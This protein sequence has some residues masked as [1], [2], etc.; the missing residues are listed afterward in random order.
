MATQEELYTALRNAD[1]A[2]DNES[3][4]KLAAYI[5]QTMSQ[6]TA[7]SHSSLKQTN[8]GEYDP[9]SPEYQ[10]KYGATSG[11]ST[12][13]KFNAGAGKAFADLGR[14]VEQVGAGIADFV[15]PRQQTVGGL[16]SGRPVQ[17][18]VDEQRQNVA[19]SRALDA[20]LMNTTAGKVGNIAGNIAA[21]APALAIP[22]VNTLAGGAALGAA[23]GALQPSTS[24][25]ETLI[26]TGIGA[27]AAPALQVAGN[28][29]GKAVRSILSRTGKITQEPINPLANQS[30]G[31]AGAAPDMS[32]SSPALQQAVRKAAQDSGGAV[33]PEVL[34]RHLEADSLPVKMQLTR[35]QATQDPSLISVEQ[36]TR[37]K[38]P[39]LAKH[40]NQQNQQL[41][42][43]LD[44]IRAS[45]APDAVG[46]DHIQNGQALIDSYKNADAPVKADIS[47]KYKTFF[48]AIKLAN[49]GGIPTR[50]DGQ[51]FASSAD[52]ALAGKMKG[53][54]LPSEIAGDLAD[55]RDGGP[56]TFETFENMRT[57][58]AAAA[59]KAD[60]S[61]DGNAMAAINIVRDSLENLPLTGESAKIKPLADAARS[62]AKARFDKLK[63][64]P[65]YRAAIDDS[66]DAGESST[67]AD[68][69]VQKYIVRGKSANLAKMRENLSADPAALQTMGAGALNYLKSKSGVNMFT[70][71][72]N[73]SQAG[74]NR[75]LA[76]ITPK[77]QNLLPPK[78]AEQAQALGNVARYTQAQPRG[79]FVNNSNTMVGNIGKHL[80][81]AIE[82]VVN[83]KAGG[84]P[85]GTFVRKKLQASADRKF[86]QESMAPGA[87]L[88]MLNDARQP[89]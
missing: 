6:P 41:I 28:L 30:M 67:L 38:N 2:G 82:G 73:F 42:D 15:S 77:I 57:N 63:S 60:R 68:D 26:N 65:A 46:N 40:F 25:G 80:G 51:G 56:M 24:T 81:S 83:V 71:E 33:N 34:G 4:A 18:R 8:P 37:G 69:F 43:N 61:G 1:A 50:F 62:A 45:A 27:V 58:L 19:D 32:A 9:A 89:R 21:F 10:A 88:N 87:G 31:A 16:V 49:E 35:G 64:D 66:V 23:G 72:G 12:A 75:A 36:N 53:R 47:Q 11:M 20:P 54:Y 29:G 78:I 13:D 85:V 79:S 5:Q 86:A 17:S 84:L 39:E 3:A 59:R 76:E 74:Y 70:N 14:G 44:E 48:A 52:K 7:D 55:L 22:G